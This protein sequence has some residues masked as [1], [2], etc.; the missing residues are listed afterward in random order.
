M[1]YRYLIEQGTDGVYLTTITREDTDGRAVS[2]A[3]V[4]TAKL[5]ASQDPST[6]YQNLRWKE[7]PVDWQPDALLISSWVDDGVKENSD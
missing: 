7:A 4:E 3:D 1:R 5:L 2:V 6:T